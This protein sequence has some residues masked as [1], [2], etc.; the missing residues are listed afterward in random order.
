M[1][2]YCTIDDVKNIS[3]VNHKKLGLDKVKEADKLDEILDEWILQASALIDDYTKNPL[4]PAEAENKGSKYYLYKNISSRIVANMCALSAA[5]KSHSVV[6]VNDWTIKTIPS[7]IF[8]SGMKEELDN[9]KE[10]QD[11]T[12]QSVY[13]LTVTGKE[14]YY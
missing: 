10:E 4:S 9:Y 5:H 12:G 3:R 13:I 2:K 8:P 6:K 7:E 11:V 1:I 14:L